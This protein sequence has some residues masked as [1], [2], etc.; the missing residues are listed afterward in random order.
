MLSPSLG[1]EPGHL[2]EPSAAPH[3][4]DVEFLCER[5]HFSS[6]QPGQ[7]RTERPPT[8]SKSTSSSSSTSA[9]SASRSMS[10]RSRS[11]TSA[12]SDVWRPGLVAAAP[13]GRKQAPGE[14]AQLDEVGVGRTSRVDEGMS[15]AGQKSS[16][17]LDEKLPRL[18]GQAQAHVLPHARTW[19]DPQHAAWMRTAT[20]SVRC[21]LAPRLIFRLV[22][23]NFFL[24]RVVF[25]SS[26]LSV[27]PCQV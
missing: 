10:G 12:I 26:V 11:A 1:Q 22:V 6:S 8:S 15:R 27:P 16:S 21:S 18:S 14:Q 4:P 7:G 20:W 17:P 13:F 24:F 5:R 23:W 19:C 25:V 3:R 9:A 2:D